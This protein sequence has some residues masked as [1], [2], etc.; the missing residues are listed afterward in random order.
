[1]PANGERII[2]SAA[3]CMDAE[4]GEIL[5]GK[6]I[7]RIMYPASTT[8]VLTAILLMEY[9]EKSE[10]GWG[11]T[12]YIS[13]YAVESIGQNASNIG[14]APGQSL[15]LLDALYAIMLASANEVCVAV[16][17]HV[18]GSVAG[19]AKLMNSRARELGAY[20]SYF[21]NP[22]GLPCGRHVTT[23][24][25]I[26][27]IMRYAVGF[28]LFV[29]VIGTG[30]YSF[31]PGGGSGRQAPPLQ[32][33]NRNLLIHEGDFFF[34]YAVGGKTGFTRASGNTLVNYARMGG[35]GFITVVLN[36]P[37]FVTYAD[38]VAILNTVRA[39]WRRD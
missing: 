28:E 32:I 31:T 17:E 25:D 34:E 19:F 12:I 21:T 8:K 15:T 24:L 30:E 39:A 35:V 14:L 22:T 26:A 13:E 6:Y 29:E 20:S 38:T 5:Y 11:E 23:A 1:M 37:Q 33:R 9:A 18:G 7:N 36:A 2:S 27:N 16:A 10:G 4:T 3:I